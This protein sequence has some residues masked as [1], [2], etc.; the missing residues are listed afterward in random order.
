[1]T[2]QSAPGPLLLCIDMQPVFVNSVPDRDRLLSRCSF[3]L[4]AA[5]GLAIQTLF[6]EQVP[7]KLGG[8]DEALL[9]L[10]EKPLQ[11]GKSTFSALADHGLRELMLQRLG[12]DHL[13]LCGIETPICVYQTAIDALRSEI[14][15]TLL[16]DCIGGRRSQDCAD[17]LDALKR[18]G[19]HV[20]PSESVFYSMLG[21]IAHP[22]FRDFTKLVKKYA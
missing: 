9:R 5:R 22:F 13:I 10:I 6:T 18:A 20:L 15:V 21:D 19:A 14:P 3:A 12:A 8:T 1:M 11:A 4:E 17:A 16:S 7:Q 2:D